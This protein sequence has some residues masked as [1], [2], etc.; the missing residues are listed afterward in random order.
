EPATKDSLAPAMSAAFGFLSSVTV[1][2]SL[3]GACVTA[4]MVPALPPATAEKPT[5]LT[6]T[7]PLLLV[8][9]T[10]SLKATVTTLLFV[11]AVTATKAGA[12]PSRSAAQPMALRFVAG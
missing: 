4:V 1:I 7:A 2:V 9:Q 8:P 6:P 11:V 12:A 10:G 3:S 5:S